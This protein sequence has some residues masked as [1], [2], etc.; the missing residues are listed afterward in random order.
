MKTSHLHFSCPVD[1]TLALITTEKDSDE[2]I[3]PNTKRFSFQ[4]FSFLKDQP[5]VYVHAI[6]RVCSKDD[7]RY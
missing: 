7:N 6:V 2:A 4:T 5:A 3:D 1:S